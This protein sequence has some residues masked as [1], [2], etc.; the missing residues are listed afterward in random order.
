MLCNIMLSK[1]LRGLMG[2]LVEGAS[3]LPLLCMSL[4]VG[5]REWWKTPFGGFSSLVSSSLNKLCLSV[6]IH[7]LAFP[8]FSHVS[9]LWQLSEQGL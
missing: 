1:I 4:F 5:V 8:V 2:W 6:P 3:C 7:F 9:P